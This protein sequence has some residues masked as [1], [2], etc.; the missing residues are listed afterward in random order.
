MVAL[1]RH[2][3]HGG[4]F[5]LVPPCNNLFNINGYYGHPVLSL[6]FIVFLYI[7]HCKSMYSTNK[8]VVV[9]KVLNYINLLC[10]LAR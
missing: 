9:V 1:S 5:I 8:V 10:M 7:Y 4:R 2:G 3:V 6:Y